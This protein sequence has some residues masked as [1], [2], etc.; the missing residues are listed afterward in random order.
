MLNER[1]SLA[2][3]KAG[4][5]CL[6]IISGFAIYLFDAQIAEAISSKT[7]KMEALY[8]AVLSWASVQI[9]F[10]FAVYGFVLAKKDGFIQEIRETMTMSRFLGYVK[11]ANIGGFLLTIA[12]IPITAL[13]PQPTDPQSLEFWIVVIWFLLFLWTFFALIRVAV[14]FGYLTA[15]PDQKPFYGA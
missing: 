10:A 8:G 13:S 15:I 6:T 5:I 1:L 14:N 2:W 7:I 12:S 9:G 4:P 3:E 11:H